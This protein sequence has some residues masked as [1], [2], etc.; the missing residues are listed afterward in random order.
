MLGIF[1]MK[2]E[3]RF[4]EN[5][6]WGSATA[7]HQIE[8]DNIHSSNW[9][10]EQAEHYPEP[11]GK[12][13]NFWNLWKEDF[14]LLSELGHQAFRMSIEW[15][16]LEPEEGVHD[17]EALNHYLAMFEELKK[18]GIKLCLTLH[19]FSHPQWFEEKGEFRRMVIR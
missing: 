1:S 10:R 4:P 17:E 3:I 13:C 16:R 12:A 14:A 9:H 6:V 7:G 8:G 2:D 15:S 5:F 11:S 19:H 18:R